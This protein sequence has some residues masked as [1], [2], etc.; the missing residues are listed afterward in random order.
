MSIF[1]DRIASAIDMSKKYAGNRARLSRALDMSPNY[2]STMLSTKASPS[3]DL[4]VK[5]ARELEVS[6]AYL[7]GSTS[8]PFDVTD[9]GADGPITEQAM[10]FFDQI[11]GSLREAA[12][13]RGQ[14]PT[15]DDMM[16]RW[17]KYGRQLS[18]FDK[19][20]EWF[21]IYRAPGDRSNR[22]EVLRMGRS[23][24]SARTLGVADKKSLQYA[25]DEVR[26]S[27]LQKRLLLAYR[28]AAEGQP[29]LSEEALNVL[30]PG[31]AE[32]IR[33]DYIR[34]LLPVASETDGNVIISYSKPLR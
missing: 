25:L 9:L 27:D 20:I 31:H 12:N 2:I 1:H 33:L 5:L 29:V 11:A 34:L 30:A 26:D 24:L 10:K 6:L 19:I 21:D 22:I 18:G 23:S 17:F 16:L 7:A 8:Q 4:S 3:W 13:M 32:Q 28:S 15:V 14:E